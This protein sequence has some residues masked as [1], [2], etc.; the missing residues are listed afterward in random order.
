MAKR[1]WSSDA[2]LFKLL[3]Y[4][5]GPPG[6]EVDVRYKV[7]LSALTDEEVKFLNDLAKRVTIATGPVGP[8][9]H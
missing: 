1:V 5:Y 3:A 4:G 7:D 6:R 9:H 8:G 2:L